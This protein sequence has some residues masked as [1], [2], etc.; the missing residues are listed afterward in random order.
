[1]SKGKLF[2]VAACF[3]DIHWGLKNNSR[4]HNQDCEQFI[5][6]FIEEAKKRNAETCIFLGDWHHHR[7]SINVSTLNYTVS[8]LEK[9]SKAFKTVYFITGNHDLFYKEKREISSVPMASQFSNVVL[10]NEPL[11]KD[12]VAIVPWLVGDEYKQITKLKVKYMFGHFEIPGFKLNAMIEMPDHGG[13]N[14][15]MFTNQEYVFSGHFHK[16]QQGENVYYIGNPFGHN[17]ADAWDFNRGAMFLE[18]DGEPEFVNWTQGPKYLSLNFSDL[19]EKYNDLPLD[20]AHIKAVT[21]VNITYEDINFIKELLMTNYTIREI[22]LV[23]QKSTES[24]EMSP[25]DIQFETVDQI[26]INELSLIDSSQY[27]IQTLISL[28]NHLD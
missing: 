11:V 27:N 25:S 7:S 28:Y 17:F 20:N 21:D 8:N 26:V 12:D 6:W 14:K 2:D 4:L 16:R 19:V 1:L 18:W 24:E 23:P 22:K 10:I 9:L 13:L 5:D 15:T 3:S